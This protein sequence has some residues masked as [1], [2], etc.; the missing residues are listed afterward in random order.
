MQIELINNILYEKV[1]AF[2]YPILKLRYD[3]VMFIEEGSCTV[4]QEGKKKPYTLSANEIAYIPA[5]T[6]MRRSIEVPL[7][8]YHISFYS[9]A[10]HPFCRSILSGRLELPTDV[11][12]SI[13]KSLRR[14]YPLANNR[15]AITHVIE[16]LFAENYLFGKTQNIKRKPISDE[17]NEAIRYM[18]L[19]I[20]NPIDIHELAARVYVRYS[21]LIRRFKQEI[22]TTPSQ[23][24]IQLRLQYGKQLLLNHN[25]SIQQISEQCGYSNPYYFTNA[26]HQYTGMSPT[27]FRAR[28]LKGEDAPE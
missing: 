18:H 17:V 11:K 14:A 24:L 8:Y 1:E 27:E 22:G 15:E 3:M 16:H 20:R 26:F 28:H 6:E 7:T 10:D 19:N 23:Y 2:K 13:F 9:Q 12:A 5:N 21:R 4:L 25:Y